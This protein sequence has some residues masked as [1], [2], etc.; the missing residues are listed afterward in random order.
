MTPND[1]NYLV[2]PGRRQPGWFAVIFTASLISALVSAATV[3]TL[4]RFGSVGPLAALLG[5]PSSPTPADAVRVPDV[6]GMPAESADEL[7]QA[8]RLRFVVHER[9][10]DATVPAGSVIAQSP[11]AQSRIAPDGQVSVVVSTGPDRTQV[12][13]VVGRALEDAQRVIEAIGLQLGPLVEVDTGEPGTVTA[14]SPAIGTQVERGTAVTISVARAKVAVPKLL[15]EHVRDAR[16]R[17]KKA[18]LAV[19]DVSE[20]YN[21]RRKGNVVLSQDPEPGSA[22]PIGARVNLT[23]NQGD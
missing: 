8:R 11:L 14:L 22:V 17:L 1:P 19:G 12:P 4:L 13:D 7:L 21:A 9:R 18:G 15:G 10:G 20:V 2:I 5:S 23:I 16:E 6:V 3:I